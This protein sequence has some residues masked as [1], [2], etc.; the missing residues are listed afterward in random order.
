MLKNFFNIIDK[1]GKTSHTQNILVFIGNRI[2][3]LVL[4]ANLKTKPMGKQISHLVEFFNIF[5]DMV[6]YTNAIYLF[7]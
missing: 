5:I 1:N 7:H 2:F 6:C 3:S 4:M